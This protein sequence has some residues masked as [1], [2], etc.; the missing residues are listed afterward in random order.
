MHDTDSSSAGV[1]LAIQGKDGGVLRWALDK[2]ASDHVKQV[3]W[4]HYG[5]IHMVG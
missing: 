5:D 2:I 3:G 4:W 1:A